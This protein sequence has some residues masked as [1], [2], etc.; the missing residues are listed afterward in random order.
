MSEETR[1]ER[2]ESFE[3]RLGRL[4]LKI[5]SLPESQRPHLY[6]LAE[7]IA[8]QHQQWSSITPHGHDAD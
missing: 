1:T 6:E 3:Q 7:A 5:D 4:R 8:R 2:G